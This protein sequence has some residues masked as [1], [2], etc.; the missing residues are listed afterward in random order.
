M[1]D[2]KG[3][4]KNLTNKKVQ[5]NALQFNENMPYSEVKQ[6]PGLIRENSDHVS[7]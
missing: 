1:S 7:I 3:L 6:E 4:N 2:Y 5:N